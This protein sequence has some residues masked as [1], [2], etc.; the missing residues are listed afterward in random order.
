MAFI[1]INEMNV[2]VHIARVRR[3]DVPKVEIVRRHISNFLRAF[4]LAFFW[5]SDT[6]KNVLLTLRRVTYGKVYRKCSLE[7]ALSMQLASKN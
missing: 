5:R 4:R 3:V 7:G 6:S 1:A 2:A